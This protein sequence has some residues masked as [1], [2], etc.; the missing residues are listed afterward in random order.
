LI[1]FVDVLMAG[2]LLS[3]SAVVAAG[4]SGSE[5]I[6]PNIVFVLMDDH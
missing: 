3:G 4:Q 2:G 1:R 5:A 6:R